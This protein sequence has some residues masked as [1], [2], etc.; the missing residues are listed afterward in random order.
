MWYYLDNFF[1]LK[2]RLLE[3]NEKIECAYIRPKPCTQ[4]NTPLGHGSEHTGINSEGKD[5]EMQL[6]LDHFDQVGSAVIM[7]QHITGSREGEVMII[8]PLPPVPI[9]LFHPQQNW[10]TLRTQA[11][12]GEPRAGLVQR[13]G[14]GESGQPT[15]TTTATHPELL[16]WA[17]LGTSMDSQQN[18][19]TAGHHGRKCK[20]R[21]L[22]NKKQ[23]DTG[24]MVLSLYLGYS[25]I[26]YCIKW[27]QPSSKKP[28]DLLDNFL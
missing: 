24:H 27:Q 2:Y 26:K 12:K 18:R 6:S 8:A 11:S 25:S 14:D 13:D 15:S 5:K 21:S 20:H 4:F 16:L 3:K 7:I 10:M 19:V 1:L 22:G 9:L 17:L 23:R 28:F